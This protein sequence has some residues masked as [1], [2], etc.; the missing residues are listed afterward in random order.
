MA[1]AIREMK[2]IRRQ[3]TI[4]A[5]RPP[6]KAPRAVAS[7]TLADSLSRTSRTPF[8]RLRLLRLREHHLRHVERSRGVHHAG[9]EQ[10][11]QR[12][13]EQRVA[14]QRRPGDGREAGGHDREQLGAREPAEVGLDQQRRLGLAQEDHRRGVQRLDLRRPQE[15]EDRPADDVHDPLDHAQVVQEPDERAEEDDH[16]QHLEREDRRLALRHQL[17]EEELDA[18]GRVADQGV[19]LA[20][21]EVERVLAHRPAQDEEREPGLQGEADGDRAPRDAAPAV[22]RQERHRQDHDDA[23][24]PPQVAHGR[25]MPAS[26]LRKAAS[27]ARPVARSLVRTSR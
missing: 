9:G 3:P 4:T 6:F 15:P 2:A 10:I 19:D 25:M 20:G 1:S 23:Q 27:W 16:R 22:G 18:L 5:I 26:S 7:I 21:D 8:L 12:R 17:A 24:Q 11:G 13:P 14:H